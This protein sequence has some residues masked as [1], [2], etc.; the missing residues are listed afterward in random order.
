MV[1]GQFACNQLVTERQILRSLELTSSTF[2]GGAIPD[3]CSCHG[4]NISPELAWTTPPARTESF[5]LIMTDKDSSPP[6]FVHWVLYDLPLGTREIR[7]GVPT[8]ERLTDGSRQGRN[9]FQG[10]G[11]GGP[12]PPGDSSHRYV[13]TLY[14][15]DSKL[16]VPPGAT[17]EEILMA[18]NGHI[19]AEGRLVG[20]YPR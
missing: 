19:V 11:Y 17:K 3:R 6:D 5:A 20:R 12:C 10:V 7:E 13:F 16:S 1:I 15:L 9:N 2:S 4:Q 14:A 8:K 18:I